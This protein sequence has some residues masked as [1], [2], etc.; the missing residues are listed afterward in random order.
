MSVKESVLSLLESSRGEYFSGEQIAKALCVTR[1]SVW[2]AVQSLNQGGYEIQAVPNKGYALPKAADVLTENGLHRYL[3]P[4]IQQIPLRV[5]DKV[6][7]TNTLLKEAAQTGA[8]DG[9][10]IAASQ[11]TAGRGR[12]G[13]S[14]YSPDK[15]GLYIS[16]LLRPA[17]AAEDAVLITTMAAV[18]MCEAIEAVSGQATAIKWVNDIF[19]GGRKV[20]GILTEASVSMETGGVDYVVLGA[21]VN[22]YPPSEGFPEEIAATAGSVFAEAQPDLHNRLGAAFLNHLLPRVQAGDWPGYI[23]AYRKRS[24][25]L[26]RTVEVLSSGDGCK[27]AFVKGIDD[28]CRLDVRFEDGSEALLSSGE[29]SVRI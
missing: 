20:C 1:A 27:K 9:T 7:S 12:R 19:M 17:M 10:V 29:I 28:R 26:N 6:T 5:F 8:A 16:V 13:R 11:Q 22:L 3:L 24:L 18:A 4:Q 23:D 2:K 25:V 15:T 21:G 14:F